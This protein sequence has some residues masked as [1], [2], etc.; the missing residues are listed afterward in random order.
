M[1]LHNL[2]NGQGAVP[3]TIYTPSTHHLRNLVELRFSHII[4][5]TFTM[6]SR[7]LL[8]IFLSP[9]ASATTPVV[10][11][12]T[13]DVTYRGFVRNN[14]EIFL[15]IPFGQDT[16]GSNRFKPPKLYVPHKGTVF[17]GDKYGPACPQPN[18]PQPPYAF[19]ITRMSEDCLNLNIGRP[20][21]TSHKDA[22]PVMVFIHGGSFWTGRNK[23]VIYWPDGMVEQ[24]VENGLPVIQ[25]NINYR[26]GGK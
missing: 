24:S 9:L 7:L 20:R 5:Q 12:A 4:L 16:G 10:H 25:V 1:K 19:N 23:D 21:Q 17:P 14:A 3:G 22:L 26:L 8:A 6:I 18:D 11:D 2:F 15:N 13:R